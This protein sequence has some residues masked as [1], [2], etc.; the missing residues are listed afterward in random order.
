MD[1]GYKFQSFF[2]PGS[3]IDLSLGG[4]KFAKTPTDHSFVVYPG[5]LDNLLD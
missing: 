4:E 3:D 1:L 2:F 5:R